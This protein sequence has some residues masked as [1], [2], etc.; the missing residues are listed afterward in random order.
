MYSMSKTNFSHYS[1]IDYESL[2][3]IFLE[4]YRHGYGGAGKYVVTDNA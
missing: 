4:K 2:I 3:P 1:I